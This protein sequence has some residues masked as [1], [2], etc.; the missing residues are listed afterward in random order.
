ML[1][2]LKA[3]TTIKILPKPERI[4]QNKQQPHRRE[5]DFRISIYSFWKDN[6][7]KLYKV[8][9]MSTPCFWRQLEFGTFF[10]KFQRQ[11]CFRNVAIVQRALLGFLKHPVVYISIVRA[12][13]RVEHGVGKIKR[14]HQQN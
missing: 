1:T 5:T 13:R 4:Q 3:T 8:Q 11:N 10:T 12:Q 2:V 6:L 7:H 9:K 14:I